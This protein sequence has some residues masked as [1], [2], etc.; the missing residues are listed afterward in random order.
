[1]NRILITG[2]SGFVGQLLINLF[3]KK[4]S[5][6]SITSYDLAP[7]NLTDERIEYINGD[8]LNIAIDKEFDCIIHLAGQPSVFKAEEK[9]IDDFMINVGGSVNVIK[10]AYEHCLPVIYFSSISVYNFNDRPL[11]EDDVDIPLSWYGINKLSSE[12]YFTFAAKKYGLKYTVF[13]ISYIYGE[14]V[15]RGPV[16]DMKQTGLLY[17]FN[18]ADSVLDFINIKDLF[19]AVDI[20]LASRF[21]IAGVYNI[22]SGIGTKIRELGNIAGEAV[23]P[24]NH[25]LDIKRLILDNAK[26]KRDYDWHCKHNVIEDVKKGLT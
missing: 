17:K 21:K 9:P 5:G 1:M 18:N 11:T 26:F 19:S 22:G 8:I 12:K 25:T 10:Y 14:G 2:G 15:Q 13:R 3:L 7:G 6:I 16:A 24:E 23:P 4:Y 20:V